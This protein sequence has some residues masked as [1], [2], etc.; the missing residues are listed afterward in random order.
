MYY[1]NLNYIPQYCKYS[2]SPAYNIIQYGKLEPE[3]LNFRLP[4]KLL[5]Y[6]STTIDD[7]FC[8]TGTFQFSLIYINWTCRCYLRVHKEITSK[9]SICG[10]QVLGCYTVSIA[11]KWFQSLCSISDRRLLSHWYR[12]ANQQIQTKLL[13]CIH[14][15]QENVYP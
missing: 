5:T 13:N 15:M 3:L 14:S 4:E 7:Q 9:L 11:T 2:T 12:I 6:P 8:S 10:R 1:L